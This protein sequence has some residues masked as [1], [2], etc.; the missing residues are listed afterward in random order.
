MSNL[1]SKSCLDHK[2]DIDSINM[3]S[4]C[5]AV[6]FKK[7]AAST[8]CSNFQPSA[9]RRQFGQ[10]LKKFSSLTPTESVLRSLSILIDIVKFDVRYS[11]Q[12][13]WDGLH[14]WTCLSAQKWG[15]P[16]G[17]TNDVRLSSR[18]AELRS[19]LEIVIKKM[20]Q[21]SEKAILQLKISGTAQPMLITVATHDIAESLAHLIDGYQIM[22]NQGSSVYKRKGLERCESADMRATILHRPQTST[23]GVGNDA[24]I[25]REHVTLKELIGGGQFG[26]VYRG[27]LADPVS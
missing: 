16:I 27:T 18:L 13:G 14:L 25:K 20:E 3:D 10:L 19:V 22:Y 23:F 15:F 6:Y 8:D 5:K 24:R 9:L 17:S 7:F 1:F 12:Y 26:N 4:H 2:I 11:G 21:S